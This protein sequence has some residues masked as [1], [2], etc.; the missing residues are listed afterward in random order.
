MAKKAVEVDL[1]MDEIS[2]VDELKEVQ[3]PEVETREV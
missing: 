3:I 2:K 1:D